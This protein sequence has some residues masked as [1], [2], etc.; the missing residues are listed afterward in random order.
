VSGAV[1]VDPT[2]SGDP[3]PAAQQPHARILGLLGLGRVITPCHQLLA[4]G[5]R[6]GVGG[7]RVIQLRAVGHGTELGCRPDQVPDAN[8]T[9][10]RLAWDAGHK[11][12][13]APD[14]VALD[15]RDRAATL[16]HGDGD[17]LPG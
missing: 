7:S 12:A 15:E 9:Q 1:H 14:P 2:R 4:P 16:G 3:S 11:W 10:Q 5:H 13:F 17:I 8:R 6:R